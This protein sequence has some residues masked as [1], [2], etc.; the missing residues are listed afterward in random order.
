MHTGSL[1][2]V[3]STWTSTR[4]ELIKIQD[5]QQGKNTSDGSWPQWR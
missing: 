1:S 2:G 4:D 3:D 5:E